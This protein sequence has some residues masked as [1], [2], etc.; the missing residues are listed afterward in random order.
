MGYLS[1]L[2]FVLSIACGG[3]V[4][5]IIHPDGGGL[6][7]I[8]QGETLNPFRFTLV[9]I[10]LVFCVTISTYGSLNRLAVDICNLL[11]V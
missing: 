8:L 7:V 2:L 1:I 11:G 9:R 6:K 3:I 4:G 5:F 10:F